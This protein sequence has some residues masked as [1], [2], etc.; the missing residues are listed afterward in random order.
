MWELALEAEGKAGEEGRDAMKVQKTAALAQRQKV[1]SERRLTPW[2]MACLIQMPSL[3]VL[4]PQA[5]SPKQC[6]LSV[7]VSKEL[8][9]LALLL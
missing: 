3:L 5:S 8:Q 4:L 7:L 6:S 9:L 2:T 1:R